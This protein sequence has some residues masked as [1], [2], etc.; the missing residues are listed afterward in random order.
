MCNEISNHQHQSL[1]LGRGLKPY[2]GHFLTFPILTSIDRKD[3]QYSEIV[4]QLRNVQVIL[5]HFLLDKECTLSRTR[6]LVNG[7]IARKDSWPWM[8]EIVYS[9]KHYCGAVLIS[10]NVV[11]TAA[12]CLY[13][14]ESKLYEQDIEIRIGIMN[15]YYLSLLVCVHLMDVEKGQPQ[16]FP[17]SSGLYFRAVVP[18][19]HPTYM[20]LDLNLLGIA[21]R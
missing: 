4:A 6:R 3:L 10:P 11:I 21:F 20:C 7:K 2:F 13:H 19:R 17:L 5:C 12:H 1:T 8:A 14:H 16:L 9:E 15:E 18:S